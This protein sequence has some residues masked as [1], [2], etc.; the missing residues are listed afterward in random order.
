MNEKNKV[1]AIKVNQPIKIRIM[2]I[3]I[4]T[5]IRGTL[6][7]ANN[8]SKIREFDTIAIYKYAESC[9]YGQLDS[10]LDRGYMLRGDVIVDPNTY[11]TYALSDFTEPEF[12]TD[13]ASIKYSLYTRSFKWKY[14]L[15]YEGGNY[16]WEDMDGISTKRVFADFVHLIKEM[17]PSLRLNN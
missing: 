4:E 17:Y 13:I 14:K 10:Y 11:N 12:K 7:K 15:S 3:G 2:D 16:D 6:V 1:K 5:D 8:E 9:L